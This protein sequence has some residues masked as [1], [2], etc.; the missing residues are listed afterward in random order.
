M[1]ITVA[2]GLVRGRGRERVQ[3]TQSRDDL[4]P[5]LLSASKLILCILAYGFCVLAVF[6]TDSDSPQL[7][8]IFIALQSKISG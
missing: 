1:A 4:Y 7:M 3:E 2:V 5:Y 6:I 8:K